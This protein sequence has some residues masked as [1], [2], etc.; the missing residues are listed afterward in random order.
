MR[1]KYSFRR[2]CIQA[3]QSHPSK[4][5]FLT[6]ALD[7]AENASSRGAHENA[8]DFLLIAQSLND[9]WSDY[10]KTMGLHLRIAE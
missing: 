9:A 8:L 2:S 10:T 3:L 7:A 5:K 4:E 6:C 1:S